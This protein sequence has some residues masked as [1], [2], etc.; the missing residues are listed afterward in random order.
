[1]NAWPTIRL[2]ALALVVAFLGLGCWTKKAN[3]MMAPDP[4][5]DTGFVSGTAQMQDTGGLAFQRSWRKPGVW[6]SEYQS[7]FVAPVNVDYL[8][9]LEGWSK[10]NLKADDIRVEAEKIAADMQAKFAAALRNYPEASIQVVDEPGPNTTILELAI[11]E[12]VPSK[13]WLGSVGLASIALGP[14]GVA[15]GAAAATM[16]D[17]S[18]AFEGRARDA[19]TQEVWGMIADNERA[20][21][22]PIN[23]EAV[24]WYGHTGDIIEEWS[25]QFA[26]V[27]NGPPGQAV[28][29][30]SFFTLSPW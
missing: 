29:D 1:M 8:V 19:S 10:L 28:E 23:V 20:K 21:T 14:L 30:T 22:R 25:Q 5:K 18:M 16:N 13:V 27:A 17:A 4:V 15:T 26:E 9:N 11:V 3:E 12:I 6:F 2:G 24:T 7:I